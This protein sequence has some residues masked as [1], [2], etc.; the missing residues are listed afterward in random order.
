MT[1]I[2][3]GVI[4]LAT[5]GFSAWTTHKHYEQQKKFIKGMLSKDVHDFT[6]AEIVEEKSKKPQE[7]IMPDMVSVA[8]LDDEEFNKAIKD[9]I[10]D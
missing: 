10:G 1:E 7:P 4:V 2:I 6:Q 8:D 5:L 3:L 9:Q